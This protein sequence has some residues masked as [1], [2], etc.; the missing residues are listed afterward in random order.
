MWINTKN[1]MD[2]IAICQPWIEEEEES[3]KLRV[4]RKM[5]LATFDLKKDTLQLWI[6]F[7]QDVNVQKEQDNNV[8][9]LERIQW[10]SDTA[11]K[12]V[13]FDFV[14]KWLN[15]VLKLPSH[16]FRNNK[17]QIHEEEFFEFYATCT[18]CTLFSARQMT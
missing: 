10:S 17:T 1:L 12:T 11:I 18:L 4:C 15:L 14:I 9:R 6:R 8:R 7:N 3:V 13:K 16:Y 5:F 2:S